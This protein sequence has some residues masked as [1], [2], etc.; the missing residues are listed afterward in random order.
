MAVLWW[1]VS[2][3][4]YL[5]SACRVITNMDSTAKAKTRSLQL[6]LDPV[7]REASPIRRSYRVTPNLVAI[8]SVSRR[9]NFYLG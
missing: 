8:F 3:W 2:K 4:A 7:A 5:L 6:V 1:G 9:W